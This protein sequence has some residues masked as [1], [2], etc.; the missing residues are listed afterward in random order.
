VIHRMRIVFRLRLTAQLRKKLGPYGD[1]VLIRTEGQLGYTLALPGQRDGSEGDG[2]DW[3]P[4]D[5]RV[6]LK[7]QLSLLAARV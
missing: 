1:E 7:Q 5:S 6:T 3:V 2:L 4:E